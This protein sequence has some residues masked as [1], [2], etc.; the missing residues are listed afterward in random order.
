[1]ENRIS[2]VPGEKKNT[3]KIHLD[4]I[5]VH[6][7]F[8]LNH[9][10]N[11]LL[12]WKKYKESFLW[13]AKLKVVILLCFAKKSPMV[14]AWQ[15]TVTA[16]SLNLNDFKMSPGGARSVLRAG[17]ALLS[18]ARG[19]QVPKPL[20]KSLL[21]HSPAR[22]CWLL[23]CLP[24]RHCWVL[25]A[26]CSP[27][28]PLWTLLPSPP[29]CFVML[30]LFPLPSLH[31]APSPSLGW[32][33]PAQGTGKNIHHYP[34]I[35]AVGLANS[36]EEVTETH[37]VFILQK[38]TVYFTSFW[39]NSCVVKSIISQFFVIKGVTIITLFKLLSFLAS[40]VQFSL[41]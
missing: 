18:L 32:R 35:L 29:R 28:V 34:Q 8:V 5:L 6:L 38:N 26:A 36:Q 3:T 1:M 27:A 30:W 20:C 37:F 25:A 24:S 21:L 19:S 15:L 40:L 31:T 4:F 11:L 41:D 9:T 23:C 17:F 2:Y 33:A 13:S 16:L 7:D 22:T 12:Q 10:A 39:F 14:P